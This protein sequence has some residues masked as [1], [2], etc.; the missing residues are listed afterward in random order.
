[1]IIY[2]FVFLISHFVGMRFHRKAIFGDFIGCFGVLPR[3]ARHDGDN[4]DYE[5]NCVKNTSEKRMRTL[6]ET[7]ASVDALPTLTEPPS[8]V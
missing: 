4:G 7:T 3:H 5:S 1:M 2:H 8:T 6:D